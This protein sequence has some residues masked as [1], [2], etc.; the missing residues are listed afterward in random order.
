MRDF[1]RREE[2]FPNLREY[3]DYLEFVETIIFNL[4]NGIQVESTKRQIED[5]KRQNRDQ[6]QRNK[7]S[8][9]LWVFGSSETKFCMCNRG[10]KSVFDLL[11]L[12]QIHY[13]KI[14]QEYK[15]CTPFSRAYLFKLNMRTSLNR[16][17]RKEWFVPGWNHSARKSDAIMASKPN[18]TRR[19][20]KEK[21]WEI[22]KGKVDRGKTKS[23]SP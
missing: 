22:G 4:T 17:L 2:E 21:E 5:Y 8:K 10:K 3:N 19:G 16:F 7:L 15:S 11:G 13:Y 23:I 12:L 6:I 1:N 14:S 20:R 18:Q 9:G